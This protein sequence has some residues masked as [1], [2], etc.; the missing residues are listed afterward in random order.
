[1][2]LWLFYFR[3]NFFPQVQNR[4]RIKIKEI[5]KYGYKPYVI[6]DMGRF[7]KEKVEMEFNTLIEHLNVNSTQQ[8]WVPDTGVVLPG[9]EPRKPSRYERAA[10]PTELQDLTD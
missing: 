1:M 5:E 9:L 7:S 2:I 4:D 8:S 3:L 6:K 10:L